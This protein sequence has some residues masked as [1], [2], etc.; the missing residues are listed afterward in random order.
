MKMSNM[1]VGTLREVPAEA[2]IESHKLML[3]AG[4]MRKMAA[5]I[6]NYMPLGLKVIENVK[7][8]VREEMNNAGA[9]EFLASALIP[10]E[11][12]QESGRWD[13]YG[14]EM[15]R[16]KDRHNRDFC[17]GPTHEEVFT[18]IVRNE[19]KSY[20]QLPLNLYQIQTKYRDERRPRFGVMRSR[21]FIMKDGY[22]FDKDQE[23]L[24]LA[25]EKMRKA[26]VNIF[27]RC[28]LDAKAVAADS[29]AIG[30]SGS[31]EFMVKSEV[32]ED[33]V[34]FC[35]ACD[36]AANIEKAPSTPEHAEK[37][38][39]ME[40]EKV[41]TPAVKS[42]EDLAKFFE[43]SPKKIAKT[44]IFQ[45]DDKVVAVV[46]RGDREANE[47]K[48][49]NAIGEVIELEMASEEAVKEATGAAVGF[50]G[51][52]GIKVDILLVDQEVA[53]MYNFIIGANETDMHLKNVNYGRDFEGI[54][55]DFRNV[56][57]GEKCPE[58]GKEITISRGTE[59]GHIF[60][61][62]T[63]YS[64][65]M[66]A[67][68]IDEDG[69]AKPF[70]MGCYGIGVTR[71]VASIIEQHND[72]NGII[73]PLEVAPYH[74]S[75]IPANV[76]NEEQATKAEEIYN[77]L[78]KMGVEALLDDRKERAGV[79]FKDSELMGIPMRITVG[80][81]IGEG[82]VEFKLRNGGEVETLSIEEV[83]NRVRK[84]F[85]RENLSL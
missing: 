27:N 15:F 76:K 40:V 24:D 10:A 82:Q 67:T 46:L 56:T 81:M 63:K 83:Y 4:L 59:V 57:I 6:Y 14:A 73:W 13:A 9:Q 77:E 75:V 32:G 31:A 53:N 17:L 7:N 2:E 12:W 21:E 30:G 37:E 35:T 50:A 47:V 42:I 33:D 80:K 11:L 41:E 71:T 3:R 26:Y 72:E 69:K 70:I 78:R 20:K 1:L 5:G 61:L 19:I 55:G 54:V 58:C 49:A 45:A 60:K 18:D 28:G 22:S 79:K 23:G 29:G 68:F 43:C 48:I 25:Y 74:V 8:I 65:S 85:E 64:E 84:E 62:G 51:P 39:L 44:L 52:M 36:Y 34:V 66:G 38:E 16:L